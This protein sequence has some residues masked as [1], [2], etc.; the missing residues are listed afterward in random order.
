MAAALWDSG[1]GEE[2]SPSATVVPFDQPVPLLRGPVPAGPEDDPSVGPFVLAFKDA[3]SWRSALEATRSKLIEQCQV[4]SLDEKYESMVPVFIRRWGLVLF[5]YKRC[6]L[7]C[8]LLLFFCCYLVLLII[9]LSWKLVQNVPP[10]RSII[11]EIPRRKKQ[12][13]TFFFFW[14]KEAVLLIYGL[15]CLLMMFYLRKTSVFCCICWLFGNLWFVKIGE[16]N[17]MFIWNK[18]LLV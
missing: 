8:S 5:G 2:F 14:E 7:W 13:Q 16:I 9:E 17:V 3:A 12:W 1:G 15:I 4:W 18:P 6:C 10:R 11:F